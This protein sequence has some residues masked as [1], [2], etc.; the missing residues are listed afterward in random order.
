MLGLFADRKLSS[1]IFN[2]N[3]FVSV[4]NATLFFLFTYD[5]V[6]ASKDGRI[7]ASRFTSPS[8]Q[9]SFMY[10]GALPEILASS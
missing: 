8:G 9:S 6:I 5:C 1:Y 2:M 10:F 7:C 3:V 4:E